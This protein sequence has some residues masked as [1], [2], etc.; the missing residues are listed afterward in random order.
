MTNSDF[1]SRAFAFALAQG[2]ENC[3][4]FYARSESFEVNAS[5]GEIERY[6]VSREAGVSVRVSLGGRQG[7]AYTERM[8]EPERLVERAMDNARCIESEDVH[9]MQTKREYGEVQRGGSAFSAL[10]EQARIAFARRME[11]AALAADPRVKR[12]V[13]CSVVAEKGA[14]QI[15]NTRGLNAAR[16]SDISIA[17]IM[18]SVQEGDEVQT[19]FAFRMGAEA[20]D[21]E[22]CAR[23]AVQDAL[24]KL[25]GKPVASGAYR[26][27]FR[28]YAF[29]DLLS[30]F[31]P[32]FSADEAQ[33]GRSLLANRQGETVAGPL[34]TI[35]DDPF[36]PAAP[37]AF[38]GEGTPSR[39][40]AVVEN[41]VLKTLLH[42]LKTAAKAGVE[43][44]GNAARPSAASTVTVAPTVF[45][46]EPGENSEEALLSALGDGLIVTEVEG[47][48]AGA[49]PISGD[50]SLKAAGF[51]AEGGKIVR[52]VSNI[53]VAGNFIAL[54]KDVIALGSDLQYA[55]PQVG[56]F[57]S[58]S[59]LAEKLTVAGN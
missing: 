7:Y 22:G 3:E 46:L 11:Q 51:L 35:T 34:V 48:H 26:V 53:T 42:N 32:M 14:V 41:G 2:C 50:F 15:E 5:G 33:K 30:A 12:V 16:S 24:D 18:P 54:L 13:Y 43:S 39:K 27:L 4:T 31:S 23:E 20:A 36:D 49:D 8:D 9:P 37:R 55:L 47:V 17:Y 44:T 59:V 10:S 38:D 19:G 52:P 45:R 57:A 29:C 40:K 58:P 28:P 21:V 25:G 1:S 56:Y 6:S